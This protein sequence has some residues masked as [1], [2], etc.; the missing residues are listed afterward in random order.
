MA[1]VPNGVEKNIAENFNRLSMAH[2]RCK[3]TD[4]DRQTDLRR[5]IGLANVNSLH[6]R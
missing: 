5:H 3:Q 1:K 6:V 4:D 2:E